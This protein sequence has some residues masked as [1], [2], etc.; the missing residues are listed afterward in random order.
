MVTRF[1]AAV[2]ATAAAAAG[3][4]AVIDVSAADDAAVRAEVVLAREGQL[5]DVRRIRIVDGLLP[6]RTYRLP[7][8]GIRNRR[9][10]A[11]TY[12][13]V[14]LR[15]TA[16]R[17]LRVVPAQVAIDAGRSRTVALR[18]DLPHEAEPGVYAVT[19]AVRPGGSGGARL[20]FS[21]EPAGATGWAR[22]PAGLMMWIVAA[23]AGAIFLGVHARVGA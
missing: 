18:L 9:G 21:V 23:V 16:H 8:V 12:R 4:L 6:G 19:I 11:T 22:R 7:A 5:L 17:W 2:I 13:L 1:T 10:R 15:G 14:V 3:T 20:T